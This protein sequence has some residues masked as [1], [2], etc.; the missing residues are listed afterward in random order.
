[1]FCKRIGGTPA[2]IEIVQIASIPL[3][4]Y[5]FRPFFLGGALWAFIA[6]L[7]WIGL[8]SG[9]LTFAGSYGAVPWHIHEFLFGY[10]SAVLTGFLLTAV[11]NWTGR[12]PLRGGSLLVLFLVWLAG[13]I[14]M[15]M[16]AKLGTPL[17]AVIDGAYLWVLTFV[18]LREIL[19]GNNW[20]NLKVMVLVAIVASANTFF[21]IEVIRSGAPDV[22]SRIGV[23]AI[24]AL[25][26][27]IGGRITPSF[28][29][30]WLVKQNVRRL[31]AP[32][33]RFDIFVMALS[34]LALVLW[35][36]APHWQPA[37]AMLLIVAALLLMRLARWQ[38][39]RTWRAPIVL[40]LHI[41]Y[42]F[43]P[44]GALLLGISILSTATLTETGA[45]HAWTTGAMGVMTLAVM[46]RATR[47]HTG[48]AIEAP[49]TTSAIY[50][51]IILAAMFRIVAPLLPAVYL[52]LIYTSAL[53]WL[54]AFG[55]FV[56]V[57][58]PMLLRPRKTA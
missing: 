54:L 18:I 1:M 50:L 26:I 40:I 47:G 2:V 23:A 16:T 30:N 5:G 44:L 15:L 21:H 35:V 34:A 4:S 29:H 39:L 20:R 11:P 7:L 12:L 24:V 3:F 52:P 41:G 53:C 14:A 43:L 28:T 42:L 36:I 10:I 46:T 9:A 56:L 13:R 32:L 37:G 22:G 58:G 49:L 17:A 25:I 51:A 31:P 33:G 27:L 8:L 48:R 57:Y 45:L 55:G 6:M 38:G 19:A